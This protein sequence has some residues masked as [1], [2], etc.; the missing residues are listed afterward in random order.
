[1]G[2]AAGSQDRLKK[3]NLGGLKR[4]QGHWDECYEDNDLFACEWTLAVELLS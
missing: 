2:V 4:V 3:R 1:M